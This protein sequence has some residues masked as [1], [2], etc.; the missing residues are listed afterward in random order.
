MLHPQE[1]AEIPA[2][3]EFDF[4]VKPLTTKGISMNMQIR[5]TGMV[6]YRSQDYDAILRIM[7][8]SQKLPRTFHEWRMKAEAGEKKL[9]REGHIIVRAY[10]DPETFPDWCNARGLNLDAQ[11]RTHY[12]NTIAAERAG[13]T[14]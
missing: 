12:A 2:V 11:A 13:S 8:D 9:Q 6:W 10:I 14:H 7:S 3:L 5:V 4:H 1:W